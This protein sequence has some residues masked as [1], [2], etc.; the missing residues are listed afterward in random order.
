MKSSTVS[1]WDHI[2]LSYLSAF[3]P[4]YNR[5]LHVSVEKHMCHLEYDEG[6]LQYSKEDVPN[7]LIFLLY[8]DSFYSVLTSKVNLLFQL[9]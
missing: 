8:K 4:Y 3:H 6:D 7:M 5:Y 1:G 2:A 9:L